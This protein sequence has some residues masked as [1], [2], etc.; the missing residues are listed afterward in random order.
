ME[1][2]RTFWQ[3]ILTNFEQGNLDQVSELVGNPPAITLSAELFDEFKRV[4]N[5]TCETAYL[6]FCKEGAIQ[7][8][9]QTTANCGKHSFRFVPEWVV[10]KITELEAQGYDYVGN[11]HHHT[12]E[13]RHMYG[14]DYD[15]AMFSPDDN[16]CFRKIIP[17]LNCGRWDDPAF[18]S[19]VEKES[20][21]LVG[22]GDEQN[23]FQVRAFTRIGS[24]FESGEFM[25]LMASLNRNSYLVGKSMPNII[26]LPVKVI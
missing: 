6:L 9:S 24:R 4:Y 17:G 14:P 18:K 22:Y 5:K 20:V 19:I 10:E 7:K 15:H 16:G 23:P 26:E 2:V 13:S 12:T 21:A 25:K 1:Y 3:D 11:Y 8:A